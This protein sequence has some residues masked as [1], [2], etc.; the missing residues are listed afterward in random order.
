[1]Q[2]RSS[3]RLVLCAVAVPLF[4]TACGSDAT[5]PT[6]V[7][8]GETTLVFVVN[9]PLNDANEAT[10]PTPGTA[11][12]G[13]SISVQG[14]PSGTTDANGV[15]TLASIEPG[16]K[17]VN[18]SGSGL[19]GSVT[20]SISDGDLHEVAVA[21][22]NQGAAIMRNVRYAFGG[23]VV[24]VTPSTSLSDVNAAL[25]RSNVIVFFRGGTYSGD[26]VFSGS[27]VTLF[28][29]GLEGGQ[30][31]LNGN[32]TVGGSNNRI[33]GARIAAKLDVSGSDFGFSFSRVSGALDKL[34][35]SNATLLL[36]AFCSDVFISG[37]GTAALGN[38]GMAPIASPSQG[39]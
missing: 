27:D 12:S 25:A 17:T 20:V 29:E 8:F 21:L 6:D 28:G 1:M 10:L 5:G 9:P 37:S 38:A 23:E 39:C 13:V 26:L 2:I 33:R 4:T 19:S 22:T 36:N 7:T 11:R 35:G 3:L 34:S 32:I 18:F 14:G 30:V 15:V 31:T 16:T 24:E